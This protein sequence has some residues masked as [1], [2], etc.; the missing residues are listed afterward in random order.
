MAAKAG[1]DGAITIVISA[2]NQ[3]AGI[4]VFRWEIDLANTSGD[5]TGFLDD[6]KITKRVKG[7]AVGTGTFEGYLDA[8]AATIDVHDPDLAEASFVLTELTGR[9]NTF[10]GNIVGLTKG[11]HKTSGEAN[12]CRGRFEI[13][14][15]ITFG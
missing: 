8:A 7:P 11:V 12:S 15:D 1:Y 3:L 14:G 2:A 9:T 4:K 5:G 13:S 6:V 10:S